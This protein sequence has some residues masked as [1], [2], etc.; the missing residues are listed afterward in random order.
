MNGSSVPPHHHTWRKFCVGVGV[1]GVVAAL[2]WGAARFFLQP[3]A[4]AETETASLPLTFP[5]ADPTAPPT[6]EDILAAG[7]EESPEPSPPPSV[8]TPSSVETLVRL[9]KGDTVARVLQKLG[10]AS[11]D[12]GNTIAALAEPGS[13]VEVRRD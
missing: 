6:S 10:V 7:R 8:E 5:L 13:A 2:G 9:S 12:I 4:S 11:G 3:T 1:L